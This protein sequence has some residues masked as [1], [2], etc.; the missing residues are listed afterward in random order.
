M[1]FNTVFSLYYALGKRFSAGSDKRFKFF[2]AAFALA[3]LLF[4]YGLHNW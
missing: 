3:G 1:I 2:V 4:L